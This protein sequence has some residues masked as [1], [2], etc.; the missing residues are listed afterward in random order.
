MLTRR[1]K[2]EL[3]ARLLAERRAHKDVVDAL[4]NHKG[5]IFSLTKV[6]V[7]TAAELDRYIEKELS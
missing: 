1:E 2:H 3:Q 4:L 5:T 6:A 7:E